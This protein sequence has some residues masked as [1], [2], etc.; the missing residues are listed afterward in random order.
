MHSYRYRASNFSL[1]SNFSSFAKNQL[2]I[3]LQTSTNSW[4][5]IIIVNFAIQNMLPDSSV[6]L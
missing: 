5:G 1:L 6:F 2:S 4:D 3:L